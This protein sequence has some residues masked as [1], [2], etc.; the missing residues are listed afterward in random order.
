MTVDYE[1]DVLPLTPAGNPTERH[2]VVAYVRAAER[3]VPDPAVFW[4]GKLGVAAD[5]M[6]AIMCDSRG[7]PESDP[8]QADE[9]RRCGLCPAR[10][11]HV[12]LP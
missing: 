10:F 4:A 12:S 1:R 2:M 6:T 5:E 8:R 11:G 9:T 3:M 7:L